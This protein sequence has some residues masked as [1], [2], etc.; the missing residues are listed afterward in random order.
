LLKGPFSD[1]TLHRSTMFEQYRFLE[2]IKN[3]GKT[4]QLPIYPSVSPTDKEI[5]VVN[6]FLNSNW[7]LVVWVIVG[8][9]RNIHGI[10]FHNIT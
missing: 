8:R 3:H 1:D 4:N 9:H 2:V 6:A 10:M 7:P 5:D